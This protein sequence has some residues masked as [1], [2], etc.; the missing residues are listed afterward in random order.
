MG[1]QSI[2][3]YSLL[4]V[5]ETEPDDKPEVGATKSRPES[6]YSMLNA[7]KSINYTCGIYVHVVAKYLLICGNTWQNRGM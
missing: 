7:S 1:K 5:E 3:A 6:C 4:S 2:G